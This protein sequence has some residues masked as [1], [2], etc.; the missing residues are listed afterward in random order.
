MN[1]RGVS[2]SYQGADRA[3]RKAVIGAVGPGVA[4]AVS[5]GAAEKGHE[6]DFCEGMG[7]DR[8]RFRQ[9]FRSAGPRNRKARGGRTLSFAIP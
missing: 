1:I 4:P 7:S 8:L 3:C 6:V 5:I 2:N 9:G